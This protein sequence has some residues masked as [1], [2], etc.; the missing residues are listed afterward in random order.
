M[1]D[2]RQSAADK[3]RSTAEV[4]DGAE[5]ELTDLGLGSTDEMPPPYSPPPPPHSSEPSLSNNA[6]TWSPGSADGDVSS[7][8]QQRN[9]TFI[10][11]SLVSSVSPATATPRS[12]ASGRPAN[13]PSGTGIPGSRPE[14][15]D[16]N[17]HPVSFAK[18]LPMKPAS[19]ERPHVQKTVSDVDNTGVETPHSAT[20]S[21]DADTDSLP[22]T[23]ENNYDK[24][25]L[26]R[27]T[28]QHLYRPILGGAT[29]GGAGASVPGSTRPLPLDS[30]P[31][32]NSCSEHAP[33]PLPQEMRPLLPKPGASN[34]DNADV[35]VVCPP[36]DAQSKPNEKKQVT[37][38]ADK[39]PEVTDIPNTNFAIACMVTLCFN[40]PLGIAAMYFSL[41]AVKAYQDG[42]RKLGE[43]RSRWSIVLSLLGITITTVIISSVVLWI[44][45]Q[46]QKRISRHKAFGNKSGLNL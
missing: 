41:R 36:S 33:P 5:V 31:A 38:K 29:N 45:V 14:I 37:I 24:L 19:N 34:A 22:R 30:P 9:P 27:P 20:P 10:P 35:I 25:D 43:S 18:P 42:K 2:Q 4:T 32:Y 40:L 21:S 7:P 15:S 1:S 12:I 26:K 44:A 3:A 17:S 23:G 6:E 11:S 39:K 46:G 8:Q 13:V 16:K 28:S